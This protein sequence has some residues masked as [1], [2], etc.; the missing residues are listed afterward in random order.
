MKR[1]HVRQDLQ[2]LGAAG[3]EGGSVILGLGLTEFAILFV[4]LLVPLL[5]IL[6]ASRKEPRAYTEVTEAEDSVASRAWRLYTLPYR[7]YATIGGRATVREFWTFT[8]VNLCVAFA[9][10]E[11]DVALGVASSWEEFGPFYGVF[12]FATLIPTV[13]VTVRRLH[14]GNRIGWWLLLHALP[15]F[16][17]LVALYQLVGSGTIGD[18]RFG[19][20]PRETPTGASATGDPT[21]S[22]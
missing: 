8:L 9:L 12:G 3:G 18:N 20:D 7:K 5:I 13:A 16:G 4:L 2:A 14:D 1:K 10:S 19:P 6:N 15:L 11:V 21:G 17:W 22:A